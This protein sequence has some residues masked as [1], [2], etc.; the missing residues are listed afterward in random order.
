MAAFSLPLVHLGLAKDFW[1]QLD[2]YIEI[3]G[4][5]TST[6]FII[7]TKG[8]PG[9][10]ATGRAPSMRVA[11]YD[12]EEITDQIQRLV[13]AR[14]EIGV[15]GID[16]WRD[17]TKGRIELERIRDVIGTSEVGVRMHWLYFDE[18]TPATLE[19]AGFSYDSTVGYNDAVG[20]RAGTTQAFKPL[21]L[22]RLLEL[23][24]HVMDTALFFPAHM[25]L[26]AKQAR[27]VVDTLVESTSRFGGV[28]TVNWHDRSIAPE[29]LWDGAYVE[30]LED[31]KSREVWFPTAI[32]AVS[33]F[34]KRRSAVIENVTNEDEAIRIN[35][36]MSENGDNL[37]GLRIRVHKASTQTNGPGGTKPKPQYT[38]ATF[39]RSGEIQI[40]I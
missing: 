30:L 27:R 5:V 33:W 35:V 6:F 13:S 26:S 31:L 3:E 2:R 19:K 34:R 21:G 29:R 23:P 7:P 24:M 16:A 1:N 9:H 10:N 32:D 18:K 28:L 11:R 12:S 15:H 38:E 17:T 25:N 40:A 20:Y 37:P 36:S 22:E 4:D 39:N 8:D 14:R